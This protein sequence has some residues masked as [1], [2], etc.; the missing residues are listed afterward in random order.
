MYFLFHISSDFVLCDQNTFKNNLKGER[1]IL[2]HGF[3]GVGPSWHRRCSRRGSLCWVG[4]KESN[5]KRSRSNMLPSTCPSVASRFQ[6]GP[7][8]KVSTTLWN[9]QL[10]W[11][12]LEPWACTGVLHSCENFLPEV[13][14]WKATRQFI[15]PNL[16]RYQTMNPILI[17]P[18]LTLGTSEFVRLENRVRLR[19]H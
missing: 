7:P 17:P 1:F 9:S 10:G 16:L 14:G 2:T 15:L 18:M 12:L 6:Q 11:F 4:S 8:P 13:W 5:K 19:D 3:R